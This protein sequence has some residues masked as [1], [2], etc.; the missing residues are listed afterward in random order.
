[1]GA[2]NRAFGDLEARRILPTKR[3]KLEHDGTDER[4]HRF[5]LASIDDCLEATR[6]IVEG[7]EYIDDDHPFFLDEQGSLRVMDFDGSADYYLVYRP[8]LPRI[9]AATAESYELPLPEL[10][11]GALPYFIKGDIY[12]MDEPDEA[13]AAKS[14]YEMLVERYATMLHTGRQGRVATVLGEGLL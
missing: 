10:L 12:R 13:N 7:K 6:L 4:W 14:F 9:T 2:I 3:I 5:H 11:A 1:V 8:M